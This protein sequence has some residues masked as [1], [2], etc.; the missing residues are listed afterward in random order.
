[1]TTLL[2]WRYYAFG[3]LFLAAVLAFVAF[4]IG[5]YN[6]AFTPT[7]HVS[8]RIEQAGLQLLDGSD[9]KVR[10][11]IV[12]TVKDITSDGSGA[13]IQLGIDPDRL[14]EIPAD[15]HAR[16]VPKTLFGEKY[17]D[18]VL[19]AEPSA[20]RLRDGDVIP[21]D[22]SQPTLE[23]NRVLDDLLPLLRAVPPHDLATTLDALSTALEGR[24]EQLG[25]T[26]VELDAYLKGLNPQLPQLRRDLVA[27]ADV[28]AVYDTAAPDLL[29]TLRNLLTTADTVVAERAT[30]AA[31]LREV[32]ATADSTRALLEAAGDDVVRV[33]AVS[34]DVVSLLEEYSPVFPCFFRGYALLQPNIMG[35]VGQTPETDGYAHIVAGFVPPAPDY[36]YPIDLPEYNETRGPN[37]YGLPEPGGPP[38]K[39]RFRDGTEDDPRFGGTPSATSSRSV[40]PSAMRGGLTAQVDPVDALL[41]P[42][43]GVP[44]DEVPAISGLLWTPVVNGNEVSLL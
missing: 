30:L 23:I 7:A 29:A 6:G 18:L 3:C 10:G 11:L 37:C 27:L 21:E 36:D 43:L 39:E 16:L 20:E 28:T 31:F 35:A 38:P 8:L 12:G 40:R 34:R 15:V 26:L 24:G 32:T 4:C 14:D 25:Q 2:R 22:R 41:A 5:S 19:P 17:V 33:N 42:T 13:Q 9:V 1:M 44:A